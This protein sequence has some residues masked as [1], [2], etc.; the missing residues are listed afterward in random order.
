MWLRGHQK[1][2]VAEQQEASSQVRGSVL[3]VKLHPAVK[4][5][6]SSAK[7]TRPRCP[8]TSYTLD[9]LHLTTYRRTPLT[10]GDTARTRFAC[11]LLRGYFRAIRVRVVLYVY[12]WRHPHVAQPK[13]SLSLCLRDHGNCQKKATN[14]PPTS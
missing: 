7:T 3:W 1:E 5:L 4:Q 6:R 11:S 12:N 14:P 13:N 8:T 9:L 10:V 2:F